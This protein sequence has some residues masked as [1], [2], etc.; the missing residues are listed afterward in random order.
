MRLLKLNNGELSL[1]ER[2]GKSIPGYA[3]LL[4]TWG[5]DGEEVNYEDLWL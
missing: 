5:L 3:I 4:H 1:V 2:S